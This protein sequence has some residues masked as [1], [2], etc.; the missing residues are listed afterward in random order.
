[1]KQAGLT[2]DDARFVDID[3]PS[4]DT[5]DGPRKE[6]PQRRSVELDALDAGLV[7][8][9]FLRF[10]RGYRSASD[11]AYHEV[12]NINTLTDPLLRVNNGT[13]RPV[14]VDRLYLDR[15]PEVVARYLAVLLRTSDWASKHHDEV[16][17]LLSLDNGGATPAEVLAS[18]G[19]NVHHS[20]RP[21][22]SDDY[23][24]GLE[25][26]KNFLRDWGYIQHDFSV[27]DDWVVREPLERALKLVQAQPELVEFEHE[28]AAA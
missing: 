8:A 23:I 4:Y 1:M 18:H 11:P 19:A 26:Q 28:T 9:I 2:R 15:H 16:V 12:I 14:T 3:A 13:P 25:T 5:Q 27:A 6:A 10:A 20:F 17:R 7:D 24:A 21:K 22:L